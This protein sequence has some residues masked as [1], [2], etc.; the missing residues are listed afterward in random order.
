MASTGCK[1]PEPFLIVAKAGR[2]RVIAA[3]EQAGFFVR[4]AS[5]ANA[6]PCDGG[7]IIISV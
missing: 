5:A 7:R 1:M 2:V 3:A 6:G 4:R